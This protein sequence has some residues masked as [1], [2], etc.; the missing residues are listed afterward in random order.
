MQEM[1]IGEWDCK[2]FCQKH[3]KIGKKK[4]EKLK[5][6]RSQ[7]QQA[8][9]RRAPLPKEWSKGIIESDQESN[10]DGD[11]EDFRKRKT[12]SS[13]CRDPIK[14]INFDRLIQESFEE[15]RKSKID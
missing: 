2:V 11:D 10:D 6:R 14:K 5:Q 15:N 7:L 8:K 13:Y 1:R 9:L 12:R 3:T 4:I